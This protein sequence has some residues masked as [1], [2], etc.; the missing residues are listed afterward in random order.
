MSARIPKELEREVE[1]LMKEEH[2]EKSAAIRRLLH[3]GVEHYRLA[4][5]LDRLRVGKLSLSRAAEEAGVSVWEII[6]E[7]A[8]R[9]IPW[10]ADDVLEDVLGRRP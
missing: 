3:L 7:A 4:R 8:R 1:R 9:R 5:A 10:V 6:D 2:L